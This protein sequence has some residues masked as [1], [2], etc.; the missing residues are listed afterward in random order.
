MALVVQVVDQITAG[1]ELFVVG[2][3]L[4]GGMDVGGNGLAQTESLVRHVLFHMPVMHVCIVH[5]AH[6]LQRHGLVVGEVGDLEADIEESGISV[7][8]YGWP[9]QVVVAKPFDIFESPMY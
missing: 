2:Q 6:V 9:A 8:G 5:M 7:Q 4:R 1:L 3:P